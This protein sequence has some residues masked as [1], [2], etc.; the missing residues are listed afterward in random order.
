MHEIFLLANINR[1][2]LGD[3]IFTG[4]NHSL[5]GLFT[6]VTGFHDWMSDMT[7]WLSKVN[8]PDLDPADIPDPYREMLLDDSPIHFTHAHLNPVN[9]M[10]SKDLLCRILAILQWEQPGWCPAYWDHCKAKYTTELGPEWQTMYLHPQLY[11][12]HQMHIK[13]QN[14]RELL[15][16]L[17]IESN[18]ITDRLI[19]L[20]GLLERRCRPNEANYSLILVDLSVTFQSVKI[21]HPTAATK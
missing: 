11:P 12:Q 15:I 19:S 16:R 5:A 21:L 8:H 13:S 17:Q 3:F 2:P 6:S 7:K 18:I 14:H 1:G 4:T 20:R 9:I 10:V